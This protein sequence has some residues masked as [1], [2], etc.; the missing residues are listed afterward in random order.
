LTG[1]RVLAVF[2]LLSSALAFVP[3][4][5]VRPAGVVGSVLTRLTAP[6]SAVLKAGG[7]RLAGSEA[8][9]HPDALTGRIEELESLLRGKDLEIDELHAVIADLQGGRGVA[10]EGV[11]QLAG[12]VFGG[13]AEGSGRVL[14]VRLGGRDGVTEG[15]VATARGRHLLGRVVRV[16]AMHC[17]V[18]PIVDALAGP[19]EV[20]VYPGT[21]GT[22]GVRFDLTPVGDGTL[23]GPGRF[24][25]EGQ[26]QRPVTVSA[27]AT[28]Y[29]S[30]PSLSAHWGLEV[31][32]VVA[33][34]A[35]EQ[36]PLR[37][38]ITVR[39]RIDTR[40]VG[41]VVLR[42]PMDDAEASP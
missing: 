27:G 18:T 19:L 8:A 6:V 25:T 28:A 38:V 9:A 35:D 14:L 22:G 15:S 34:Q 10:V 36:S 5:Y 41:S 33:V 20:I 30:D 3:R 13:S 32:S 42:V 7:D 23:R 37:Q 1:G 12:R 11:R 40:R 16:E 17:Q 4:R 29:L 39:P 31:G 24:V 2:V 21:D 26:G